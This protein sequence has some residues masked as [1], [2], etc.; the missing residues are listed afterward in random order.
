VLEGR[1]GRMREEGED[2]LR[3]YIRWRKNEEKEEGKLH[4]HLVYCLEK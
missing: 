1:R 4:S 3:S 2:K